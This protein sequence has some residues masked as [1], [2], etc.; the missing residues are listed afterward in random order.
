MSSD[1]PSS[2]VTNPSVM[3]LG[4]QAPNAPAMKATAVYPEEM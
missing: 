3:Y 4:P 1:C 2:C